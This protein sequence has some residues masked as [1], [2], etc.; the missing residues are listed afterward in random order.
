MYQN[1][2]IKEIR[3]IS[4][5]FDVTAWL[6]NNCNTNIAHIS[7]SKGNQTMKLGRLIECKMSNIFSEK[8]GTKCDGEELSISLDQ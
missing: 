3:L 7:R 5:F 1:G 6:T 8:S 4:K 2:L